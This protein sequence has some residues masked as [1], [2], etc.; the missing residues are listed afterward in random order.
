ML[1]TSDID[2][3]LIISFSVYYVNTAISTND[4]KPT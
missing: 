2:T 3:L 4:I 1:L